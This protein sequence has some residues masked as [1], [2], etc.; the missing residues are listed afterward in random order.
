MVDVTLWSSMRRFADGQETVS[1][2]GKTVGE[3]LE[4]LA[5]TYPGLEPVIE[6]GASLTVNGDYAGESHQMPVSDG[7]EIYLIQRIKGG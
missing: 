7:D 1:V 3:V 2:A 6:D 4:S 5:T